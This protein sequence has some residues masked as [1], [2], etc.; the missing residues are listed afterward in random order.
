MSR[1]NTNGLEK[2]GKYPIY[3]LVHQFWNGRRILNSTKER[4]KERKRS[5]E[6]KMLDI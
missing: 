1:I 4:K 5:N 6:R 2:R 3:F